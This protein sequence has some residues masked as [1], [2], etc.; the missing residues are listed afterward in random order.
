[1]P[2][3]AI[4]IGYKWFNAVFVITDAARSVFSAPFSN[5]YAKWTFY[6]FALAYTMFF[7]MIGQD[8]K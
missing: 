3:Y 2:A 7:F 1:M 8:K 5:D 6:L 4:A